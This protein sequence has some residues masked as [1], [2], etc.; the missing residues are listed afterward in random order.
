MRTLRSRF[1]HLVFISLQVPRLSGN[2]VLRQVTKLFYLFFFNMTGY[3]W[4]SSNFEPPQVPQTPRRLPAE[5]Q[6]PLMGSSNADR[7]ANSFVFKWIVCLRGNGT[8]CSREEST[9]V[10]LVLFFS[11]MVL[12][13]DSQETR[14]EEI[15]FSTL[16][17]IKV[18]V[19]CRLN[20]HQI[21]CVNS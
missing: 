17:E 18:C 2:A 7:E 3:R 12:Q 1:I 10:L 4:T 15:S 11:V 13:S 21:A 14:N 5:R 19:Y 8:F 16:D 20:S 9:G 6:S